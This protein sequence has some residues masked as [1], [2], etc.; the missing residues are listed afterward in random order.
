MY[1]HNKEFSSW[2]VVLFNL[3]SFLQALPANDL[4]RGHALLVS[5]CLLKLDLFKEH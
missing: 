5:A 2:A 4:F 3:A 1:S